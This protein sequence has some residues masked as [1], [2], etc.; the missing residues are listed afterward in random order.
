[1][2]F[3]VVLALV[4][5]SACNRVSS[6]AAPSSAQHEIIFPNYY[7]L[8]QLPT[9]SQLDFTLT[10]SGTPSLPMGGGTLE[11]TPTTW[12]LVASNQP[13]GPYVI[14]VEWNTGGNSTVTFR[15]VE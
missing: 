15:V 7:G 10:G 6:P 13:G 5:S 2:F 3:V 14:L 9:R 12:R 1:M 8:M 11:K 4:S